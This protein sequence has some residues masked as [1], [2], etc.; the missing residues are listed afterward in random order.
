MKARK[1]VITFSAIALILGV[2]EISYAVIPPA[3]AFKAELT[4]NSTAITG[5]QPT[6]QIKITDTSGAEFKPVDAAGNT[7]GEAVPGRFSY[8][9]PTYDPTDQ[10]LGAQGGTTACVQIWQSGA[11][12]TVTYPARGSCPPGSGQITLVQPGQM[13]AYGTGLGSE[14]TFQDANPITALTNQIAVSPASINFNSVVIGQTS[15]HDITVT[16]SG[17]ANLIITHVAV[18]GSGFDLPTTISDN[19]VI[20]AGNHATITARFTS[21]SA[22]PPQSF[23]GTVT[24]TSNGYNQTS[25]PVSLSATAVAAPVAHLSVTPSGTINFGN[26]DTD[27]TSDN[28]TNTI[29]VTSDGTVD[30]VI[31][32]VSLSDTTNYTKTSD[33]CSGATVAY[34]SQATCQVI[35]KFNPVTVGTKTATISIP[36]NTGN[37][38]AT[39]NHTTSVSLTGIGTQYGLSVTP[40]GL[41]FGT[42]LLPDNTASGTDA[43]CTDNGNGTVSCTVTVHNTGTL[44]LTSFVLATTNGSQFSVTPTSLTTLA[45]GASITVTV[46]YT[47]AASSSAHTG[48]LTVTSGSYTRSV[49]LTGAT[50]TRPA[51]PAASS[52]ANAA[53]NVSLTPTLS[54]GPFSD[55]DSDTHVSST[56]Q[57][58]SAAGFASSAIVFHSTDDASNLTSIT[59]PPGALQQNTT[60]YWSVSY[61][62]SRGLAS[63]GSTA[64]SFTTLTVQMAATTGVTPDTTTVKTAGGT[65]I[66]TLSSSTLPSSIA[67]V[68]TQLLADY[69]AV[70]CGASTNTANP[71]VA[72]V[73][74]NGG[75]DKNV[76][77]IATPAGT[78]IEAVSTMT[79]TGAAFTQAPP[80]GF[81]FPYGVVDFRITDVAVGAS[82]NVTIYTPSALPSNAV[83]YKYS[84]ANGWLK[85][86]PIG[87]YNAAGTLLSS[88]TTFNV[89]SGNGVLTIKDDDITDVSTE[90]ISGKGVIVD[91]GAPGVPVSASASAAAADPGGSGGGGCFIATAAF[92]SYFDPY[93]TILRDFRDT[94]LLTHRAGR[95]FVEWYYRTS[96][97]IAD[98]IRT[99]ETLRAGV[100]LVLLPAVGFSALSLK[101]GPALTFILFLAIVLCTVVV[102]RKCRKYVLQEQ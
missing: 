73:R 19:T 26:N 52:P 88:N 59:V 60:Y 40:S 18:S 43:G 94:F 81:T 101:I 57:I 28:T 16:N 11:Q 3:I 46:T 98:Y 2:L 27:Q 66:T 47:A 35:V 68:S 93:V 90:V 55:A 86:N 1:L 97:P 56:W 78:K 58:A 44:A 13:M 72:I 54:A 62:D 65:E 36:S 80:T 102:L 32:T 99:S 15:S 82:V 96:P 63:S 42:V 71:S 45:S 74:A 7:F 51:A 12:L 75:I 77:G 91:P 49:S 38:N 33:T 21:A 76:L 29:T 6:Y 48:T 10:P 89:V 70:N 24:I 5:V 69:S 100:R 95:A 23:S 22:S 67:N 41:N 20:S 14:N 92:G 61:K 31:G 9:I 34:A 17:N 87:T 37:T 85:V 83:W 79:T 4:I 39:V 25:S 50:N 30:L 8:N 64:R 84:A 53:T